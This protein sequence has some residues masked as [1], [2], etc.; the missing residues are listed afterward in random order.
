MTHP[1]KGS[2]T[3]PRT[4]HILVKVHDEGAATVKLSD[5]G[6][7]KNADSQMT[8]T[9]SEMRGSIID[10]ALQNFKS[11]A[12]INEIYPSAERRSHRPREFSN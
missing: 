8:H 5:F 9:D 10:P 3:K 12:V 11:Y 6:L 2:G 1:P 7:A 4:N